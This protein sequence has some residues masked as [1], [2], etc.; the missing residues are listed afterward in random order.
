M[1]LHHFEDVLGMGQGSVLQNS[2]FQ[3]VA[4]QAEH[5][6]ED[7]QR[8]RRPEEIAVRRLLLVA[9]VGVVRSRANSVHART[10]DRVAENVPAVAGALF[11]ERSALKIYAVVEKNAIAHGAQFAERVAVHNVERVAVNGYAFD[12][13]RCRATREHTQH[14]GKA[15]RADGRQDVQRPG[16]GRWFSVI[17]IHRKGGI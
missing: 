11:H 1:L 6:K 14:D 15:Q 5:S 4:D 10:P 16:V 17:A 3:R 7:D 8:Q 9:R 2:S 13:A 12:G